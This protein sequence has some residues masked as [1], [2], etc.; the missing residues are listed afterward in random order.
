MIMQADFPID[1]V[2]TWVNNHDEDWQ[3]KKAKYERK[4]PESRQNDEIAQNRYRDFGLFKYWFRSIEQN[5]SWVHKIYIVTDHQVPD[6]LNLDNP[7]IKIID[8]SEIIDKQFLPT[9]DSNTI[10]W[11]LF[12]IPG[13]SEH[14]V[15]FNDDCFIN[16]PVQPED[17]FSKDGK[18]RDTVGQSIIMPIEGYDHTLV[19]NTMKINQLVNKREVLKRRW[20]QFFSFKQGLPVLLL[21]V[22]LSVFPRFTRLYDAH[23]AYSFI[24]SDMAAAYHQLEPELLENFSEKFRTSDDYSIQFVRYYQIILGHVDVRSMYFGQT[25]NTDNPEKTGQLLFGH[26]KAKITNVN[27]TIDATDRDLEKIIGLFN[28]RFPNASGFE[29]VRE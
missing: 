13:L 20:K 17:F 15:Y 27:D 5:A 25:A 12:K 21:N 29:R 24:K 23:T 1:F 28:R 19:N 3:R 18:A 8:H 10:E 9:F 2:V 26:K 6:F 4:Q 22:F 14:F 11:N 7:K 16:Q